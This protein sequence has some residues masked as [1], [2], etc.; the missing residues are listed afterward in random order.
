MTETPPRSCRH[1]SE[2]V[3]LTGR[4]CGLQCPEDLPTE[5]GLAIFA[6]W[7][8]GYGERLINALSRK[9]MAVTLTLQYND[10]GEF[11]KQVSRVAQLKSQPLIIT[12]TDKFVLLLD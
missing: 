2:K 9:A 5:T 1:C 6:G 7:C 12:R 8:G 4:G 11:V 3:K 10:I